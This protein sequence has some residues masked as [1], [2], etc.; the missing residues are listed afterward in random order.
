MFLR[1]RKLFSFKLT[2]TENDI[3]GQKIIA[4]K[5]YN[6]FDQWLKKY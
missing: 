5:C 3:P 6:F 1:I 4:P 2:K